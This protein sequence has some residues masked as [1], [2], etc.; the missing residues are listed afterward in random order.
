MSLL[1]S[2]AQGVV[3]HEIAGVAPEVQPSV[4]V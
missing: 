2:K 3:E 1:A 4:P